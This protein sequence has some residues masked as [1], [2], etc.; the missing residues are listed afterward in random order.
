MFFCTR[1][2]C[3]ANNFRHVSGEQKSRNGYEFRT[4]WFYHVDDSTARSDQCEVCPALGIASR[5]LVLLAV[6]FWETISGNE[7]PWQFETENYLRLRSLKIYHPLKTKTPM[8]PYAI[9][10]LWPISASTVN[11]NAFP[12]IT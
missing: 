2:L 8:K 4:R 3:F 6:L 5:R 12:V 7:I 10:S 1:F 9:C 11:P